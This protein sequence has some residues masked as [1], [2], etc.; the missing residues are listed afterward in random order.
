[1]GT[2]MY[3]RGS[4]RLCDASDLTLVLQLTPTPPV[5]AYVPATKAHETQD[6]YPLDLFLC[7]TCGHA[8]LLDVVPPDLLFG[9]YIYET[10]SSPGLVEHFRQYAGEVLPL[11]RETRTALAVDIGSNDGTLLRFLREGGMRVLGVDAAE[12]IAEKASASGLETLP[13]FFTGGLAREIRG[14]YGAANL[15]CAN[16]VFAHADN[17]AVM[18]DGVRQLLAPDGVFV[19]EV[20]YILDMIDNMVF[21]F[22]YHEHLCHHSVKPLR[23]F[24][25][26]HG[27]E[28]I[29]VQRIREK[30]GSLRCM[31]QLTGGPRRVSPSVESLIR[32]EDAR[33]LDRPEVFESWAGK[34]EAIRREI[35]ALLDD[36]KTRG[37]S[38]AGYGASATATVLMYHFG[39]AD[40]V[41]FI[42]DDNP[43][44]QN[45]FSPG[46]HVPVVSADAIYERRP[47]YV[48]VLAWRFANMILRKHDEYLR[49]GGQFIVPLPTVAVKTL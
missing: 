10:A 39:L 6:T 1:M 5:D 36:L 21:D 8:Q 34:I 29:D 19:F 32:S 27:M 18:A 38:G 14:Q 30:G 31:A 40:H 48:F 17:L 24:L 11:V 44:R 2:G 22:I 28:L 7:R 15:V 16:N 9:N 46:H 49:R 25:R 37:K 45:L 13:R 33:G 4:C 41:Q 47:D 3:R 26:R 20:S 42:V 35:A 23:T 43:S 12:G